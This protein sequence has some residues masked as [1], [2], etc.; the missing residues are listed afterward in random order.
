MKQKYELDIKSLSQLTEDSVRL[1]M[2][3]SKSQEDV[4]QKDFQ[5]KTL[6]TQLRVLVDQ[7]KHL[8]E[9]N[10]SLKGK[11]KFS[12]TPDETKQ[13]R[14]QVSRCK[15][16]AYAVQVKYDKM[17]QALKDLHEK[18]KSLKNS[19]RGGAPWQLSAPMQC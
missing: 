16:D 19:I 18:E 11:L 14:E 6:R 4:A 17:R 10:T 5:M 12:T 15:S 8:K 13:L 3:L 2:E 1:Q 9:E 7:V